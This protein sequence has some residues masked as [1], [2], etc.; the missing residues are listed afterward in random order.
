MTLCWCIISTCVSFPCHMGSLGMRLLA[1]RVRWVYTLPVQVVMNYCSQVLRNSMLKVLGGAMSVK[2]N[3]VSNLDT[4]PTLRWQW[5][6]TWGS[7]LGASSNNTRPSLRWQWRETW[8]SGLG[9]SSSNVR[10]LVSQARPNL[11]SLARPSRSGSGQ[12]D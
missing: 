9:A 1:G 5:R 6:E 8:G 11:V 4:R 2:N 7:G 12:W 3:E 10:F